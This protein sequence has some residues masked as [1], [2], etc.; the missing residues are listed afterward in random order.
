MKSLPDK[1]VCQTFGFAILTL[2][3]MGALFYRWMVISDESDRYQRAEF[4]AI[5]QQGMEAATKNLQNP[6][7]PIPA[8]VFE[9]RLPEP[10]SSE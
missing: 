1:R 9:T 2:L 4:A 8:T 6:K 5:V 7:A 3:L 10:Q